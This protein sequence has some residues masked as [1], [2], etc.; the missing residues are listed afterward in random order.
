MRN[1]MDYSAAGALG[2]KAALE[3]IKQKRI[4]NIENYN[5]TPKLCKFCRSI[6]EYDK[7]YNDYCNH[8]CSAKYQNLIKEIGSSFSK[9][10]CLYCNVSLINVNA[11]KYCSRDHMFAFWWDLK[12]ESVKNGLASPRVIKKF[13]IEEGEGKCNICNLSE[14]NNQPMPLVLDH[15]N[16]N[17]E[18][19]SLT[20]LRVICN[21]CDALTDHYKGKNAGNG[22]AKRRQR[23]KDGKSY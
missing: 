3:S 21:N 15:I 9:R 22:R 13:L 4:T 16:G 12:K 19:N 1:G 10:N 14:W 8:S 5:K 2:A 18:D 20:N 17:S 23:Y 11:S 7:R 6:I